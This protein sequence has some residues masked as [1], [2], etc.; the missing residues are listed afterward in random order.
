MTK[1]R[2]ELIERAL[3]KLGAIGAGQSPAA[4]DA[5]LVGDAVD[6]IMSDLASRG[7]YSW[8]DPN[9]LD[10]DA[11][12]HLAEVLAVAVAR[13]FGKEADETKRLMAESRLRQLTPIVLS[14]Q[15]QVTEYF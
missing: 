3:N 4:E 14:G 11:F 10:D 12:E 15:P 2:D 1:T 8:G 13:D 5:T 6:P 9:A 7:I